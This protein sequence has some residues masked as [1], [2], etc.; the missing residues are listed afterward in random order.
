MLSYFKT[1]ENTKISDIK[2]IYPENFVYLEDTTNCSEEQIETINGIKTGEIKDA[3]IEEAFSCLIYKANLAGKYNVTIAI[4]K[5]QY[6]TSL[7]VIDDEAPKLIAKDFEIY[8]DENYSVN[9]FVE[10]CSDNSQIE[11]NIDYLNTSLVDYSKFTEPG[12]YQIKLA[13]YDRSNNRSEPST[14]NLTIK[15]IIYYEVSF[16]S[17][18][19][20]EIESQT[21]REGETIG[22][23]KTPTKEGYI[24]KGWFHNN[25]EFNTETPINSNITLIAKW[26]KIPTAPSNPGYNSGGSSSGGSGGS[27]TSDNKCIKYSEVYENVDIY[28]YQLNGGSA[29]DCMNTKGETAKVISLLEEYYDDAQ[30][31]YIEYRLNGKFCNAQNQGGVRAIGKY[32]PVTHKGRIVGY[33]LKITVSCGGSNTYEYELNCSSPYN[34]SLY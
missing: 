20:S 26:E 16:N 12:T 10:S 21:I 27:S 32:T 31:D 7:N 1:L 29:N 3:N 24:F 14:V 2:V 23:P 30:Q 18:G 34:C 4:G 25:T 13:A 17:N 5:D 9:D 15:E 28:I 6:A 11:C 8:E 33:D 19:G 22:Y